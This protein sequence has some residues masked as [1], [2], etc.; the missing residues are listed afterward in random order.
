MAAGRKRR[1]A[2][3]SQTRR[4][5]N[6]V[7]RRISGSQ[8][9][10]IAAAWSAPRGR[11]LRSVVVDARHFLRV[12]RSLL[13]AQESEG[14]LQRARRGEKSKV[15]PR[16]APVAH[17]H[18]FAQTRHALDRFVALFGRG[19]RGA[20]GVIVVDTSILVDGR[21]SDSRDPEWTV[22][23]VPEAATTRPTQRRCSRPARC[24]CPRARQNSH[25]ARPG[26]QCSPGLLHASFSKR[27]PNPVQ[28]QTSPPEQ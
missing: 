16:R 19:L 2:R 1:I 26:T 6:H 25:H 18:A 7:H 4:T 23:S 9:V 12:V 14:L 10:R 22:A 3:R 28:I 5:R 21:R 8:R 17:R 24:A 11:G 15:R 13:R 27:S 20:R